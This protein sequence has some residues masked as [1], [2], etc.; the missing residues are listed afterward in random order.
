MRVM[1][2]CLGAAAEAGDLPMLEQ[3]LA[4][5]ADPTVQAENTFPNDSKRELRPA[6]MTLLTEAILSR[7]AAVVTKVLEYKVDMTPPSSDGSLLEFALRMSSEDTPVIVKALLE[8]GLDVN[9]RDA[10]LHQTPLFNAYMAPEA[11]Q[12]L[13]EAGADIEARDDNGDTPLIRGAMVEPMVRELL[14][15]GANPHAVAK[16]GDTALKVAKKFGC[17]ACVSLLE[18]AIK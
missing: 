8:K 18:A 7:K 1:N 17:M 10:F 3:W 9:Q 5:G 12:V 16:N 11:V 4:Q 2:Q 13:L 6:P 15:H 14:V